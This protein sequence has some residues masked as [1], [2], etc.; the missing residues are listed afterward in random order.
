MESLV[1]LSLKKV[2]LRSILDSNILNQE[3]PNPLR[4]RLEDVFTYENLVKEELYEV[5]KH[6]FIEPVEIDTCHLER[7]IPEEIIKSSLRDYIEREDTLKHLHGKICR[8]FT[9]PG[10]I[11]YIKG[12][13]I[14]WE[15]RDKT[16]YLYTVKKRKKD[17][18][19]DEDYWEVTSYQTIDELMNNPGVIV[20]LEGFLSCF[21][22]HQLDEESKKIA[23][24]L[25]QGRTE[26]LD[27]LWERL[28][29]EQVSRNWYFEMAP[30][31]LHGHD[32][33]WF[34]IG[35]YFY[36]V[37]TDYTH[38]LNNIDVYGRE[39]GYLML[40]WYLWTSEKW[41]WEDHPFVVGQCKQQEEQI[42]NPVQ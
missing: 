20:A 14:I 41:K 8:F 2:T 3:I 7:M 36:H 38:R 39:D 40:A 18:W 15:K 4:K 34:V 23:G 9:H 42:I 11:T 28:K 27:K 22:V 13:Q 35:D 33:I 37:I 21:Y 5:S 31:F 16:Y 19:Q 17:K 12:H 1:E 32:T 6:D 26:E 24:I 29:L 10:H 30:H 25:A